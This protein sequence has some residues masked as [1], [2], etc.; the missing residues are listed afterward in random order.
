MKS[1]MFF[2]NVPCHKVKYVCHYDCKA[3]KTK[4]S[5]KTHLLSFNQNTFTTYFS[6]TETVVY[7]KQSHRF[8]EYGVNQFISIESSATLNK[9]SCALNMRIVSL[10]LFLAIEASN[11]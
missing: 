2:L 11:T 3:Y 1:I 6:P 9:R 10:I 4:A 8:D 5:Y 7:Y